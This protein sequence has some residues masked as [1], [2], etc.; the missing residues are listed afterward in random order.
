VTYSFSPRRKNSSRTIDLPQRAT[1]ALGSHR[2]R[3]AED[4]GLG[5]THKEDLELVLATTKGAP[6]MPRTSS[7]ATLSL[8]LSAPV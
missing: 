3:Q 4:R 8:Y 1:E 2:K 5:A 6:W 7:T